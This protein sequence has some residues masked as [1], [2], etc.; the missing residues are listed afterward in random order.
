[1]RRGPNRA[2]LAPFLPS[3]INLAL[4]V[5][6]NLSQSLSGVTHETNPPRLD[7]AW[8]LVLLLGVFVALPHFDVVGES[9]F[10]QI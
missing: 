10:S 1:M 3:D 5:N 4:I 8:V 9:G 6:L 7:T 2:R